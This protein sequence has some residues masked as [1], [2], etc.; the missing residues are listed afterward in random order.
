VGI[1]FSAVGGNTLNGD[2]AEILIFPT[3]LS[4]ENRQKVEGY[5]G[6]KWGISVV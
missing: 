2:I 6:S 4:T 1:G 3:A 5:L